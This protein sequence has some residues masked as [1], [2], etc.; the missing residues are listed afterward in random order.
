MGERAKET[1]GTRLAN[2]LLRSD[3]VDKSMR[4]ADAVQEGAHG[5]SKAEIW[6]H[7]SVVDVG[8]SEYFT[9]TT[10]GT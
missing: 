3:P 7:F 1:I 9:L 8:W 10:C 2:L 4:D 5:R 6:V